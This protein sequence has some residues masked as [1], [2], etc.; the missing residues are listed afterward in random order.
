MQLQV[1]LYRESAM[2]MEDALALSNLASAVID[3]FV[4][5]RVKII[6]INTVYNT[7]QAVCPCTHQAI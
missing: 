6:I 7:T 3:I 5:F 1:A 2:Y 4:C